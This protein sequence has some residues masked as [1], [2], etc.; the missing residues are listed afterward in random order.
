MI[1]FNLSCDHDHLFEGWFE[2][3]AKFEAQQESR[4]LSCPVC[5]SAQV[6]KQLHAPYVNTSAGRTAPAQAVAVQPVERQQAVF[7]KAI[8]R[9]VEHVIA[10]T[11]DVGDAFPEEARKIYYSEAP[12]RA[13]RG[14][15]TADEVTELREEGIDVVPVPIPKHR[16]GNPH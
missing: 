9:L 8:S 12:E 3:T 10:N 13:I 7:H 2:S 11:D 14:N 6:N 4:L 16:L 15:A 1:V 5:G